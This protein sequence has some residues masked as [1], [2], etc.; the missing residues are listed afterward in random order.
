[1]TQ[2]DDI[3]PYHDAEVRPTIDRILADPEL[4]DAVARLKF[5]KLTQWLGWLIKPLV[6]KKLSDQLAGVNNVRGFQ[7]V[8]ERYMTGMI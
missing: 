8:V 6:K 1:M 5:P 3:R 7:E 2:F 4:V